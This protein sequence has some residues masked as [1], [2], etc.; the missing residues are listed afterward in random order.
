MN[1]QTKSIEALTADVACLQKQ[2][3]DL[4]AKSEKAAELAQ[5]NTKLSKVKEALDK[6]VDSLV[7]QLNDAKSD[8]KSAQDSV[9]LLQVKLAA[10]DAAPPAASNGKALLEKVKS[11]EEKRDSLEAALAEW[12]E[13]AKVCLPLLPFSIVTNI[14]QRS[15]K[16]YKDM[17][18]TYREAERHRQEARDK[19][20]QIT[21][22]KHEL[23]AAKATQTNG[24][25]ATGGD[26]AYWKQKYETLLSTIG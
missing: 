11:L 14:S 1:D 18:P 24:I 6:Q 12:T 15:Y 4:Q 16:E 8:A 26:S 3:I 25:G 13:L 10:K 9:Q 23:A 21:E 5:A 19:E 20:A 2:N 22:L 17:L 7:S